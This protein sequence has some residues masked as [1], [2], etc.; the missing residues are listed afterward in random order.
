[1]PRKIDILF[2]GIALAIAL[3]ARG[4]LLDQ[5]NQALSLR[6]PQNRFQLQ[7]SGLYRSASARFNRQR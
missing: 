5:V 6:D 7:L 3:E 4:D 2:A 1:M